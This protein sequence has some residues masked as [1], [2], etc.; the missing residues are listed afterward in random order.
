M[1]EIETDL[2]DVAEYDDVPSADVRI[3]DPLTGAPT[4]VVI[5][6]A[7]PEH[8]LRR[9]MA[10]DRQRKMRSQL[11][12]TG[13]VQLGDPAEDEAEETE[14][15]ADCT[16]GWSGISAGGQK[17]AHSRTAALQLYGDPKRQWLRAQVKTALDEREAF[18]KRSAGS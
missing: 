6:L 8:P 14:M 12:R 5:T 18:I 16:L 9:K 3:K 11:Q 10:M 4:A 1:T 17:L 15:L 2:F 13:K 7:G